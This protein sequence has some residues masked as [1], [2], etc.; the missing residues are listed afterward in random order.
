MWVKMTKVVCFKMAV[1]RV[2]MRCSARETVELALNEGSDLQDFSDS[3][4][5]EN[6]V[7]SGRSLCQ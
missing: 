7:D 2:N 4:S 5:E 6:I 1:C 3:G